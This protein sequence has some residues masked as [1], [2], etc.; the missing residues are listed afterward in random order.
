MSCKISISAIDTTLFNLWSYIL[1]AIF[2]H[3]FLNITVRET[4]NWCKKVFYKIGPPPP[5][6]VTY[7]IPPLIFVLMWYTQYIISEYKLKKIKILGTWVNEGKP[8]MWVV[9]LLRGGVSPKLFTFHLISCTDCKTKLFSTASV[10]NVSETLKITVTVLN[11]RWCV[12]R[13]TRSQKK[14]D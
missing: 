14:K 10:K 8:R 3:S 4:Q 9:L 2:M 11:C 13:R 6:P 5:P 7:T 1:V 12:R